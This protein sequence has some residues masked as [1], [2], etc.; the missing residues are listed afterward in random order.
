M[1]QRERDSRKERS[2]RSVPLDQEGKPSLG[3]SLVA[4]RGTYLKGFFFFFFLDARLISC[5]GLHGEM[6]LHLSPNAQLYIDDTNLVRFDQ[7][8][9]GSGAVSRPPVAS[10]LCSQPLASAWRLG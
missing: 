9:G 8:Q 5:L 1:G 3:I 10:V 6:A 7:G 2:A 4:T